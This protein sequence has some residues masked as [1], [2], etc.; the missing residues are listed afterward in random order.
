MEIIVIAIAIIVVL[1]LAAPIL[2][3]VMTLIVEIGGAGYRGCL[4]LVAAFFVLGFIVHSC[5]AC[6]GGR[7]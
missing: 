3:F 6:S 4:G 2:D 1:R 7:P 5:N